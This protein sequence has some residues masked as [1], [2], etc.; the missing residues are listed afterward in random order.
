MNKIIKIII[1]LI[2]SH[3]KD[4]SIIKKANKIKKSMVN[5]ISKLEQRN[6][7]LL[8]ENENLK[9]Q[10]IELANKEQDLNLRIY[11][12]VKMLRKMKAQKLLAL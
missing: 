10:L 7:N 2:F 4:I 8:K 1:Y 3:K 9:Q 11:N 5:I 6:K 12:I